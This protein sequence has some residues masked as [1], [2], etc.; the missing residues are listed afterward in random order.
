MHLTGK[1]DK[2]KLTSAGLSVNQT[3]DRPCFRVV[4]PTKH[5]VFQRVSEFLT[6]YGRSLTKP[7][8]L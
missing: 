7:N 3:H 8:T 4:Q 6:A 2:S 5:V 1:F